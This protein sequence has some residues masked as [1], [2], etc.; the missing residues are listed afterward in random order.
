MKYGTYRPIQYLILLGLCLVSFS[1]CVK[2]TPDATLQYIHTP[3]QS[4]PKKI[5]TQ[6]GIGPYSE[7]SGRLLVIQKA[8]RWQVMLNW[9]SSQPQTGWLRLH[10]A[11][12][13]RII[14]VTWK[15]KSIQTRDNNDHPPIWK[16]SGYRYLQKQGINILPEDLTTFLLGNI[17]KGFTKKGLNEWRGYRGKSLI[18]VVWNPNR[19]SFMIMDMYKGSK[20]VLFIL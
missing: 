19:K 15:N 1:S 11:A 8:K 14:E 3:P 7:F 18:R 5:H 9:R 16:Q 20:I 17:P 13:S 6:T 10:H 12:S 4:I 2:K